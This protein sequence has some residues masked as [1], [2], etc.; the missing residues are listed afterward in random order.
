MLD[1]G[2]DLTKENVLEVMFT[3][4]G[5]AYQGKITSDKIQFK[6]DVFLPDPDEMAKLLRYIANR[7]NN[8]D[9]KGK[10]RAVLV[11]AGGSSSGA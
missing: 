7:I 8:A 2:E 10:G 4:I 1:T 9:P 6:S 3:G 5:R 11:E